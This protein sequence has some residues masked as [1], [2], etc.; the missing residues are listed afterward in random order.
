MQHIP[1]YSHKQPH[2]IMSNNENMDR[3][4]PAVVMKTLLLALDWISL[5]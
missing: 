4:S 2:H 1:E 5:V 3:T